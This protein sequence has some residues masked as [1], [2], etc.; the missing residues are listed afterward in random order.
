ME[1]QAESMEMQAQYQR[2]MA[3]LQQEQMTMQRESAKAGNIESSKTARDFTPANADDAA[4]RQQLRRG[5]MSTYTR[6]SENQP[7]GRNAPP[8]SDKLGG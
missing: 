1:M 5:L 6:F 3:A 4:R 8:K 2:E 7:G